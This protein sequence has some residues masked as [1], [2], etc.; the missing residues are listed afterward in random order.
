VD[1]GCVCY[2]NK[3]IPG[4][5]FVKLIETIKHYADIRNWEFRTKQN[6][7]LVYNIF[8]GEMKPNEGVR[9]GSFLA[10]KTLREINEQKT[11]L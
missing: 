11:D 8:K 5:K 3:P 9:I 2:R 1:C 6:D 10:Q 7:I 4:S